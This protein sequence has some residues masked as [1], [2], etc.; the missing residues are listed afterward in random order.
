MLVPKSAK[1]H[2]CLSPLHRHFA[3]GNRHKCCSHIAS[4]VT[5]F[6]RAAFLLGLQQDS[7]VVRILETLAL[8][9]FSSQIWLSVGSQDAT[10]K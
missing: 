1:V 10:L 2:A 5:Q 9:C 3:S 8:L 4:S 7:R 6:R